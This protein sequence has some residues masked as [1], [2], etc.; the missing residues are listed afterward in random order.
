MLVTGT[1][2]KTHTVYVCISIVIPAWKCESYF[3]SVGHCVHFKA[4]GNS[5]V[6]SKLN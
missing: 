1:M 6:R 4:R 3:W 2:E 5:I